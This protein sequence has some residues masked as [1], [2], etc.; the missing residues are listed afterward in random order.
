MPV[1]TA[2]P[3]HTPVDPTMELPPIISACSTKPL[4]PEFLEE[5]QSPKSGNQSNIPL[6]QPSFMWLAPGKLTTKKAGTIC[7]RHSAH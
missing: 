1:E 5:T 7:H 6:S 4:E 2:T 3:T